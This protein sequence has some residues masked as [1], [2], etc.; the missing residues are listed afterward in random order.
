MQSPVSPDPT[1][2]TLRD[3]LEAGLAAGQGDCLHD[4][5]RAVLIEAQVESKLTG[6]AALVERARLGSLAPS[7]NIAVRPGPDTPGRPAH[8]ELVPPRELRQRK[9]GSIEGRAALLHA[10]AHIEFNAINLALD[11]AQRF[12]GMPVAY[13]ADWLSVAVDEA[14]HFQL[15]TQRLGELG[16]QYGDFPAHD[17]LWQMARISADDPLARMALVPRLLEARGLDV[18]PAMMD[19]LQSVGD[20]ASADCLALILRE[21]V[22]HVAIGDYWYRRFCSQIA[23]C[24]EQ[25]FLDL[26]HARAPGALRPPFNQAARL[27]AGF[28]AEELATLERQQ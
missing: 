11:A 19:R 2:Q 10:V 24:P 27:A 25:Q 22:R 6:L 4:A 3:Q 14:R 21:E 12:T 16:H 20:Q 15:L 13:Y 5:A 8:P 7:R 1:I 9:L 17:G 18:T 26:L 28:S 23:V